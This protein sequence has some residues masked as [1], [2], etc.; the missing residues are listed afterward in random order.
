MYGNA[1]ISSARYCR[2]IR[3][4]DCYHRIERKERVEF[5]VTHG[6]GMRKVVKDDAHSPAILILNTNCNAH[7]K[8]Y[9]AWSRQ[10]AE[11][12]LEQTWN[13]NNPA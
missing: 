5:L 3:L 1:G 9:E 4:P 8:D 12:Y 6:L 13:G 2:G 11:R 7:G 10:S